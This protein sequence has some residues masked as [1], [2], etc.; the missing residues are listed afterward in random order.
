MGRPRIEIRANEVELPFILEDAIPTNHTYVVYI[1]EKGQEYSVGIFPKQGFPNDMNALSIDV[2]EGWY[3]PD[4]PNYPPDGDLS[5]V[6]SIELD[7]KG[8]EPK[9]VFEQIKQAY[10]TY[11]NL[12]YNVLTFNCNSGTSS[13]IKKV[14][15]TPVIPP[16][17]GRATPG[18]EADLN[19]LGSLLQ[20]ID[21]PN[22]NT[23]HRAIAA[24]EATYL[25]NYE[26]NKSLEVMVNYYGK[27]TKGLLDNASQFIQEQIDW[28]PEKLN[29]LFNRQSFNRNLQDS[30]LQPQTLPSYQAANY[31]GHPQQ[32]FAPQYWTTNYDYRPDKIDTKFTNYQPTDLSYLINQYSS[33]SEDESFE[34]ELQEIAFGFEELSR[35]QEETARDFEELS[36][37]T[38]RTTETMRR[39]N[40]SIRGAFLAQTLPER[41]IQ[42]TREPDQNQLPDSTTAISGNQ[43]S[44]DGYKQQDRRGIELER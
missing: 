18:F 2:Q 42:S 22:A 7:T 37:T 1:N 33:Q 12:P 25:L 19:K 20:V 38:A 11:E 9:E 35:Q 30:Q 8:R 39:A 36:Q 40:E 14:G 21:N 16:N 44:L 29:N 31:Y 28:F 32:Q 26:L 34:L 27:G 17:T 41:D 4:K 43:A 5:K 15:L 13:A 10:Y 3:E 23:M 24:Q 6:F